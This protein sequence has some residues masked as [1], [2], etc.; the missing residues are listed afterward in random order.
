[1]NLVLVLLAVGVGYL[2]GSIS[3]AR[4]VGARVAPGQDLSV[5]S[6]PVDRQGGVL[7]SHGVSPS[8]VR[9]RAG[10]R[11]GILTALLDIAKAF[12]PTLAFAVAAPTEP[13]AA[14]AASGAVLGHVWPVYH[15]F[16]GGYGQSPIVG[17]F[18]ALDWIA[19]PATAVTGMGLGILVGDSLI[20]YEG[21]PILLVPWAIWRGDP[22]LLAFAV[23]ANGVYWIRMWPD[24]RQRLAMYR[25]HPRSWRDRVREV[26]D[27][28]A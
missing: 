23:V 15:R 8:A 1:M 25:E 14:A 20:A 27:E 10:K 6:Y 17:G 21:W 7:V 12:L 3:F 26:L 24:V 19:I 22:A 11:W 13:A 28:Y 18:L 2:A 4:I 16:Q 9:M 5:T